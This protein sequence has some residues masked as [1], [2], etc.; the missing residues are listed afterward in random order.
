[1]SAQDNLGRQFNETKRKR[2]LA[3]QYEDAGVTFCTSCHKNKEFVKR[4]VGDESPNIKYNTDYES[5]DLATCSGGC[6]RTIYGKK[7]TYE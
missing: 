5:G 6:G 3:Y 7:G 2:T 1:M 4:N